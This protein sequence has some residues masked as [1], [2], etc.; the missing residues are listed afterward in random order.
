MTSPVVLAVLEESDVDTE[1]VL[2]P[3]LNTVLP[4][5]GPQQDNACATSTCW[6]P[7]KQ[8]SDRANNATGVGVVS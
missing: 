1:T 2:W 8:K 5:K 7:R 4:D 6:V 3:S